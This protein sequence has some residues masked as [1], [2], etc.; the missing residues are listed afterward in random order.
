[1]DRPRPAAHALTTQATSDERPVET[2]DAS[3]AYPRLS[4]AQIR[5]L[6]LQGE[7]RPTLPGDLLY[8]EGEVQHDFFVILDGLVA[9]VDGYGSGFDR[10]IGVHGKGRFLGEL[11]L[12]AGQPAFLTAVVVEPGEVLAVPAERLRAIVTQD[13]NLG[14]LILRSLVLRRSTLIGLGAGFRIIGSRYSPDTRRIRDFAS[15]NRLPHHWIDPEKDAAAEAM[16]RQ[17]GISP[18]ETPVVICG[19]EVLRN[20]SNAELA[21]VF[22]L[23]VPGSDR[24]MGD[25]IVVG[26]GPAG[27]AASVYGASEGLETI[28]L[29]AMATGGQAGTSSRIENYLGFPAGISGAELADRAVVQAQKF[30]AELTL[31]ARAMSLEPRDDHYAIGVEDGPEILARTVVIATG[32]QYRKLPVPRLDEFEGVS[33]YYA[34]TPMEAQLCRGDPVVVVGGGNSAGQATL[35]LTAYADHVVLVVREDELTV[36]MS[37]YLADRIEQSPAVEVHVHTE[38]RELCGGRALEAVVVED[39]QTGERQRL[40]ARALFVFIGADPHTGWLGGRIALDESGYILT[41]TDACDDDTLAALGTDEGHRPLMLETSLPCV[42]AA[43]DVRSGSIKRVASAVGEGAMAVRMVHQRIG[44]SRH[45]QAIVH[46][47]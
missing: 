20:P 33:V 12:L 25:L 42:F 45:G 29:D 17:L 19:T 15:R 37:R 8:R 24:T 38:I 5:A 40:P 34:A 10:T 36:N 22:G 21:R 44:D 6:E 32:V 18:E 23:P 27:L 16:L 2:E 28:A 13:P 26:A 35:F 4:S 39:T 11:G 7:R 41:G 47:Q 31:P 1:M 9:I 46:T 3:G 14:D 30:G 43:G